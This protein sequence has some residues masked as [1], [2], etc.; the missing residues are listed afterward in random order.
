MP[1]LGCYANVFNTALVILQRKGYR[2]WQGNGGLICAEKN[3][4]DFTADDPVQLL[5]LISIYESQQPA[6]Y[7]EYWWK[8]DEP[9]LIEDIADEP[10]DYQ[11]VWKDD[12]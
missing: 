8:I 3:G 2:V 5:G 9:W 11:P 7:R 4:W 12:N 1:A 10:P 6:S